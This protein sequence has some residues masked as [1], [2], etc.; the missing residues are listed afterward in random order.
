LPFYTSPLQ[1]EIGAYF[2]Y[3]RW[4]VKPSVI[5]RYGW[6]SRTAVR[7][8]QNYITPLRLRAPGTTQTTT[9]EAISDFSIAASLRHDFYKLNILGDRSVFRFTPQLTFTAGTQNYGLNES[10]NTYATPKGSNNP[11][12]LRSE[13]QYLDQSTSF[14]PLSLSAFLK[15]ELSYRKFFIQPQVGF[16]YFFPATDK[17]FTSALLLNVGFVF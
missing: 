2:T 17:H 15:T 11:V 4:W 12:V 1:N 3:R 6:G 5:A 14:Q 16:H 7:E 9:T 10:S 13:D 8:R